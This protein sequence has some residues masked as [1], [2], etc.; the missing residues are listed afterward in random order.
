MLHFGAAY[1]TEYMPVDRLQIDL[2]LMRD[3]GFTVI[4]VGESVWSTWEP[5]DGQFDVD[6]LAPVLDGAHTR[7][8][9]VVLGTPTYAV[10][11]WLQHKVPEIAAEIGTGRRVAWGARQEI[12][13][14]HPAYLFHAERVI[15]RV[16]ARYAPHP[17]VIGYQLDNEPGLHVLHNAQVFAR[18]V[19][20]LRAAYGDVDTLNDRWGLTHWSHRLAEWD[21]L[22]PPDGNLVPQYDLAWRRFQAELTTEFVDWQA[23]IVREYARPDQFLTTCVDYARPAVDDVAVAAGLDLASANIYYAA[24][25]GLAASTEGSLDW[26]PS[27]AWSLYYNADRAWSTKQA[28]YLVTETN[29]TSVG[30]AWLNQP[31]Y[32]GQWRQVGWALVSRGARSV[33]YWHWHTLHH[34]PE[35]YWGGILPHSL[36]PDRVYEQVAALGGDLRA[37]GDALDGLRPDAD[38]AFVHSLPSKWAFE[39]APPLSQAHGGPDHAAYE[40]ITSAFYRGW[41]TAGAQ[42]RFVH[43]GEL[44]RYPVVVAA[45]L[46]VADDATLE[47]L[48]AYAEAGG[49]LVLGPRTGYADADGR[50]RSA[51]APPGFASAAGVSYT[52]YANVSALPV[53]A[54]AGSPLALPPDARGTAWV[55]GLRSAGATPLAVYDDPHYGR[56]P[57]VTTAAYGAG[58]ITCVGTVPSPSLAEA[59]ARWATPAPVS[60]LPAAK[61]V[62]TTSARLA[63]GR[64]A[65]FV[66]NWSATGVRAP[67]PFEAVDL[68]TGDQVGGDLDLGAWDV[69]VLVSR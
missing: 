28:P 11:P 43:G 17:A 18:F 61:P 56:W 49:H 39:F 52:E 38:V 2:D 22:W 21:E 59:L 50:V 34:G 53:R 32:D 60:G 66:H 57:A 5:R 3:A 15:R 4:R 13:I 24:R 29:A 69:R 64:R 10:P 26:P 8:I 58:R 9:G 62:H 25:D 14:T 68:L 30:P 63:D 27:G 19:A 31:G 44:S 35:A 51:L 46:Y 23:G 65:W 55:D 41:W 33:Q 16:L 37:A 47:L 12:D 48:R 36:V 45:G 7:G 6:W 42:V 54:T 1:Y 20:R 40:R 67:V